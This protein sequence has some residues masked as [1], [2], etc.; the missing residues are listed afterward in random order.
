[1]LNETSKQSKICVS[2][3]SSW[4]GLGSL[5]QEGEEIEWGGAPGGHLVALGQVLGSLPQR[6]AVQVFSTSV[7]ACQYCLALAVLGRCC[8]SLPGV[9]P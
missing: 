1:M 3:F 7:S 9:C 5:R 6:L 2:L 4:F 8:C